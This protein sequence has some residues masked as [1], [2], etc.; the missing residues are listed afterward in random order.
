[1]TSHNI[2]SIAKHWYNTEYK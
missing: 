1:M 2:R